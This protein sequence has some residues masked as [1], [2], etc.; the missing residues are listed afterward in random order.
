LRVN[1][2][3]QLVGSWNL[4]DPTVPRRLLEA[5]PSV[6]VIADED[7]QSEAA[8]EM[9]KQ[10]VEQHPDISVIRT[11]LSENVLRVISTHTRS[12]QGNNLFDTIRECALQNQAA[13]ER[14]NLKLGMDG[15]SNRHHPGKEAPKP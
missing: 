9:T 14:N 1:S 2:S 4:D 11:G 13:N 10:I 8:A 3:I 15:A 6:V 7:L 5:Q 12:A